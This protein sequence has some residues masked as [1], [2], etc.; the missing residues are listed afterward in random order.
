M[1]RLT[2]TRL[3]RSG[4]RCA[5]IPCRP[6]AP[7]TARAGP[8]CRALVDKGTYEIGH[9][10]PALKTPTNEYGNEGIIFGDGWQT[11]DVV[12]DPDTQKF[13]SSK[14]PLLPTLVAGEYWLLQKV[15][16]WTLVDH[17][18][19]VVRTVLLTFNA[20]PILLYLLV[21]ARLLERHGTTDWGR[22]FVLAAACFG[23]MVTPFAITLNNHTIAACAALF[24]L[25]PALRIWSGERCPLQFLAAGFF[26][27]FAACN[28]LPAAS[29]ALALLAL[30]LL[31]APKRALLL[32]VPAALV[33][34]AGFF[35]TN[36]AALGRLTPA[37]SEFGGPWYEYAGSH[38]NPPPNK[39]RR[40]IDWAGLK[41]DKATYTLHLL[42][43]H[44]GLFSLYPVFLLTLAG[45]GLALF[46][47]AGPAGPR[48][49]NF[50]TALLG[51]RGPP[52]HGAVLVLVSGLALLLLLVVTG[53]YIVKSSNY[54]GWSSGP[55]WLLWM[56]PLWLLAMLPA[57]DRLA[58]PQG[59]RSRLRLAGAV[60]FFGKLL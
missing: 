31:W 60:G 9:R 30:L 45:I 25:A 39:P 3:G 51:G 23:T 19:A 27:G 14:P 13:Y 24:A 35:L 17:P 26:A 8:R 18:F 47:P 49:R 22:I 15:F 10:D 4:R 46:G 34:V 32:T 7:T 56:T 38:W 28:E 48:D 44:H 58:Q 57:A 6:S 2:R 36:Y 20:L 59:P 16:G 43:G 50:W 29:L 55:R 54:G 37:Y 52:G 5:P 41:E 1:D 12:L 33:P 11:I 40:G 42:V 21:L 53:F